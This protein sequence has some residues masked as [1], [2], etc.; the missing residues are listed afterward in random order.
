MQRLTAGMQVNLGGQI[1]HIKHDELGGVARL[2]QRVG[3]DRC[4]GL[5]DITHLVLGQY[6]AHGLGPRRT[7]A[8]FHNRA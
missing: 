2:L 6:R 1:I 8:V 7:I 3:D 4:D 5:T